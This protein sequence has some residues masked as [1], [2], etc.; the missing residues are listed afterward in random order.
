[1]V[2]A[3]VG[4]VEEVDLVDPHV[5]AGGFE[6]VPGASVGAGAAEAGGDGVGFGDDLLVPVG[7]RGPALF[8]RSPELRGQARRGQSVERIE[9]LAVDDLVDEPSH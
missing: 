4:E 5:P 7:E 8:E 1:V 9:V 2:D 3:V 6:A